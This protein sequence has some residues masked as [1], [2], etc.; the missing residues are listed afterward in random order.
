MQ[1]D[2]TVRLMLCGVESHEVFYVQTTTALENFEA[3]ASGEAYLGLGFAPALIARI[4]RGDAVVFVAGGHVGCQQLVGHESVRAIRDLRGKRIAIDALGA[5]DHIQWSSIL[6]YIGIDPRTDIAWVAHGGSEADSLRLFVEGTVDACLLSPP[7]S[8]ELRA[9]VLLDTT[10]DRPWSQ[11]FCCMLVANREFA[12]RYP[13]AT[14]RA[15][16]AILKAANVC[17]LEP[18]R[19]A[20]ALVERGF[21]THY[22]YA[23][24]AMR[25]VPYG[26]WRD[27]SPEDTIRFY[28]LRLHE[29]GMINSTPQQIIAQGTDW[30]FLT[31]LKQELKE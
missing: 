31:A 7:F 27:Y 20:R 30:R 13:V 23:A 8:Q 19:A 4:D 28:A 2:A 1:S 29:V 17:A 5:T 3:L 22:E 6:A 24:Q 9:R 10:L 16:R 21:T 11:Y 25:E 26:R 14:K 15:L 18:E 12:R